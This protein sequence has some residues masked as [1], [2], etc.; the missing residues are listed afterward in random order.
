[1]LNFPIEEEIIGISH[2][3]KIPKFQ[4]SFGIPI[5]FHPFFHGIPQKNPN[6]FREFHIPPKP[7]V[8]P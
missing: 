4:N 3:Y 6:K 8:S 7:I 5:E 2:S 1:M